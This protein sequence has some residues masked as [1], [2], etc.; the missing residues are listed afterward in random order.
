MPKGRC[1][2]PII[3]H[4][5]DRDRPDGPVRGIFVQM[6]DITERKRMEDELFQEKEL[7]RL[8][9][10]SIGDAVVSAPMPRPRHLPQPQ[11]GA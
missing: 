1:G 4:T 3:S 11:R 8:T 5:P 2:I 6:T 9:L 7:M 10:Q